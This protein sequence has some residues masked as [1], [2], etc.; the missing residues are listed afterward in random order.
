MA[1]ALETEVALRGEQEE[2]RAAAEEVCRR[3][4]PDD[5]HHHPANSPRATPPSKGNVRADVR[6]AVRVPFV[7]VSGRLE[8]L[9]ALFVRLENP[10]RMWGK[11]GKKSDA[12][13]EAKQ[14]DKGGPAPSGRG[15]TDGR[16][17]QHWTS[18]EAD[19]QQRV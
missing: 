3:K 16:S 5:H 11:Q 18:A 8:G 1:E 14:E 10:F 2:V 17:P 13:K 15:E 7:V 6:A 4:M 19:V 12:A 9:E